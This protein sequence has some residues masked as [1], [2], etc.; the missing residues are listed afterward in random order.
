MNYNVYNYVRAPIDWGTPD[1]IREKFPESEYFD[2]CPFPKPHWNGLVITWSG[3]VFINP[4]F[5]AMSKWANKA[6]SEW[7]RDKNRKIVLLLPTDRLNRKYLKK[8]LPHSSFTLVT[9]TVFFKALVGQK[10]N[11]GFHLPVCL[12]TL[13][14]SGFNLL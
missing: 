7:E 8:W 9:D 4:P 6:F 14:S 12:L 10:I 2:P 1:R 3:N 11:G 5:A 13:G